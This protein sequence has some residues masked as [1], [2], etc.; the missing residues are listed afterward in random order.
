MT[1]SRRKPRPFIV[2][3]ISC[4]R[5][6]EGDGCDRALLVSCCS[7]QTTPMGRVF[8]ARAIPGRAPE[9]LAAAG[10]EVEKW[11]H[12][13]PAPREALADALARADGAITMVVDRVDA[14]MLAAAPRLRILAN[15]AVGYDNV[16]PFIAAEAGVWLTNTPGVLAE[17]S[18]DFA[19]ALLLALARQLTASVADTLAGGWKT[20][21]PTAFL[22]TD[23]HGATLGIVGMGEIGQ[24]MARRAAGFDMQ[25]L[26]TSRTR[27]PAL[28]AKNGYTW[29]TLD[30]LL[31][32][33]D[34]VSIHTPLTP[35]TYRLFGAAEFAR[36][37]PGAMLI[38]TSRGA[39]VDQDALAAALDAHGLAGAALDVTDPEPLPRDHRLFGLPNVIISPHI[40]SASLAT[41]SRMAEMAAMNV[42]AVLEGREPYNPVNRPVNPR[43]W[44]PSSRSE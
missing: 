36:M 28:E 15:M 44:T 10:H 11:P 4:E 16:D 37:K 23:V 20:W 17:T 6:T 32:Q 25:V 7:P 39:V 26:Y 24:A 29:S 12:D 43:S 42:L 27:K 1:T 18:A 9:L 13:L 41:R 8:I 14:A 5:E 34:F 33:A 2:G 30:G 21:T 19:F 31:S 35:Q 40:A 3:S 38:N 22:G